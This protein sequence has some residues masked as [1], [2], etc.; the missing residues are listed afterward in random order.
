MKIKLLSGTKKGNVGEII[1]VPD[2][3]GA[4]EVLSLRAVE[5]FGINT[6][7]YV[8]TQ[9][10]V[11][12]DGTTGTTADVPV[13]QASLQEV[14]DTTPQNLSI[15]AAKTTLYAVSIYM[16]AVGTAAAGHT[17]TKTITYTAANGSGTQTIVLVLP[18]DTAN[19]VMETYPLLVLGG[20]AIM[21]TGVYGGGATN[22]PFTV[23]ERI[24]E[25]P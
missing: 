11:Y 13:I 15:T 2:T 1:V 3:V 6:D 19:V 21:T 4:A 10:V 14:N 20:T 16:A 25:M 23:S 24:V 9:G 8:I 12:P 7:G 5:I 18:L 22:D 17:Y